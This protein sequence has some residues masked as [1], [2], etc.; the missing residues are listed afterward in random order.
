L[1]ATATILAGAGARLRCA[2]RVQRAHAPACASPRERLARC[3][4]RVRPRGARC[5]G[6]SSLRARGRDRRAQVY[7]SRPGPSEQRADRGGWLAQRSDQLHPGTSRGHSSLRPRGR[8]AARARTRSRAAE[9]RRTAC[10]RSLAGVRPIF[11][12]RN[13]MWPS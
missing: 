13:T 9:R 7:H 5:A 10:C 4:Q 1:R 12:R 11:E 2:A 3:G 6:E 8:R